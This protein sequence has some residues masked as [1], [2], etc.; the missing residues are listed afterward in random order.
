MVELKTY[1]WADFATQHRG[2]LPYELD[3]AQ[4]ISCLEVVEPPH[5]C[6]KRAGGAAWTRHARACTTRARE[7]VVQELRLLPYQ[8]S[9][10]RHTLLRVILNPWESFSKNERSEAIHRS[11]QWDEND[12]DL[13]RGE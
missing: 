6:C 1:V 7:M 3:V 9:T 8:W 11:E 5:A 12:G 2:T 4:I 13:G 10:Y